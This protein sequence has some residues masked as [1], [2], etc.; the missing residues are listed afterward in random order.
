VDVLTEKKRAEEL[1]R[2]VSGIRSVDSAISISTDGPITDRDVEF[3]VSEELH[4]SADV[5][6][7]HI[8]AKSSHG[9]VTLVG[10]T[11][12]P[13]EI[14]AARK[15]AESGRGVAVVRSRVKVETAGEHEMTPDEIFHSQV[16][17]DR[18]K[19]E[20]ERPKR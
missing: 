11:D 7:K 12:D 20:P 8:G 6:P 10:R 2:H 5:D 16:R 14:K 19:K 1:A 15:A 17:N 3:E 18:E 4:A 9:V 13:A